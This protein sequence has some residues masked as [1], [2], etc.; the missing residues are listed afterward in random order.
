MEVN[1]NVEWSDLPDFV[2][3]A[4][5][6]KFGMPRKVLL[7]AGMI[8]YKFNDFMTLHGPT[9]NALSPW[10]SPF[11]AYQHDAGWEQKAKIAKA[12]GVSVREWGRLTSAVKE[13]WNSMN[14]LL[15]ITLK[16]PVYGFFGGFAQM[17]RVDAG[18][19]SKVRPGEQRGGSKNL[20]GGAT[21]FYIPNLTSDHVS[22]W[23]VEDLSRQ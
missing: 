3:A 19:A 12:N 11:N 14:Y 9:S 2:R 18:A 8:I 1:S 23:R 7:P 4:F 13:N 5:Q 15:V 20:P 22:A 6:T 16:E 21:Q 10:W 17:A